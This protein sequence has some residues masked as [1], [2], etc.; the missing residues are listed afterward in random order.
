MTKG[1]QKKFF[2]KKEVNLIAFQ[3]RSDQYY[4]FMETKFCAP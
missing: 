2:R 4:G 1:A 3:P